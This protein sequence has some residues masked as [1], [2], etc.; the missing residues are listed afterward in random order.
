MKDV[1]K[2]LLIGSMVALIFFSACEKDEEDVH[3]LVGT[4]EMSNMEQSSTYKADTDDY[5]A[6]GINRGDTLGSGGLV[7]AQFSAMGVN[8]TVILKDDG[9][10]TLSGS[11]PVANDTLGFAPSIIPLNDLGTWAVAEDFSTILIDGEIYDLGGLLTLDDQDNPK[12]ISMT[13][14][15][16]DVPDTVVLLIDANQDGIP[17]TP[18]DDFPIT[19]DSETTLGWTK[20]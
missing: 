2:L 9:T 4:W 11:F 1:V 7:W 13:Y 6:Y 12:V 10:F 15:E 14:T 3:P 5:A 8:G 18:L 16:V 20:Q 17:E 19:E